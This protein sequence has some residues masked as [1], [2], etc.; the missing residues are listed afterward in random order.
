VLPD[1]LST[2]LA[3]SSSAMAQKWHLASQLLDQL[4]VTGLPKND[5]W[6]NS[7]G[8]HGDSNGIL[9]AYLWNR[10]MIV[11]LYIYITTNLNIILIFCPM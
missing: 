5:G 10:G 1:V 11:L 8:F 3:V 6:P 9:M 7:G 4:S 2:S